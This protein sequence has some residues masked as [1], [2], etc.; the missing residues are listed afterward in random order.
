VKAIG[1]RKAFLSQA[2]YAHAWQF[3]PGFSKVMDSAGNEL[4]AVFSGS[5]SVSTMLKKIQDLANQTLKSG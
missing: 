3:A 4:N 5:E 2:Q 1:G